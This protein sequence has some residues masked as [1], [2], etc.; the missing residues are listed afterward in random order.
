MTEDEDMIYRLVVES[1][2]SYESL[3]MGSHSKIHQEYDS[4]S[5]TSCTLSQGHSTLGDSRRNPLETASNNIQRSGIPHRSGSWVQFPPPLTVP[6]L[7]S[8]QNMDEM[9]SHMSE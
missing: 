1:E 2:S 3:L 7:A 6:A 9:C 8:E 4:D 5:F